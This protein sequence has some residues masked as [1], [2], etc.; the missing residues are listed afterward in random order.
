M[1]RNSITGLVL[2]FVI[3]AGS[4]YLMQPSEEELKR[5][6]QLQDS[7]ARARAGIEQIDSDTS[8]TPQRTAID[9]TLLS[10]PFGTALQGEERLVTLE[11]EYIRASISTKGGRVKS[12]ALKGE[13]T[14]DGQPLVLFDGDNNKFG[15][16][17]SAAGKNIITNDLYFTTADGDVHVTGQ[18]SASVTL[19]LT[20]ADNKYIDY[21]YSIKGDNHNLGFT[22]VTK[23]LQ[24]IVAPTE[25][26]LILNWEAALTQKEK[27]IASERQRSTLYYALEDGEVDHLGTDGDDEEELKEQVEWISF[28]QHFFSNVLVA[29]NGFKGGKVNVYS[30]PEANIIKLFSANMRLDF[31]RQEV[32]TY[33]MHFFFGPNQYKVLKA[34]GYGLEK[35]IDMGW[36]PMKWINRFITIPVF[37]FLDSFNWSY[38]LVI[39][40][41]T[42]MLK[43]VL[44]PLTYRSYVSMAKM[45]VL[46]PE[47]DQ[48]KEKVGQDNPTL[49]QQE[50]LKLYKQAGVNPLGGCIPLLLQMPFTIA[51]FFFFPNLFELRGESFLW[52]KDLS[53]YDSPITFPRIPIIGM[54]HISLMCILMTVATLLSTWYNNSISGATG[55][56]K[57]IGYFMPLIFLF[58]LN[59]FP[60]GLNYYYLLSTVFTFGQQLVIRQLIN[61]DKIL[62]II[63]ANKKKPE[64]QKKSKFQQRMEEYMRQQQAQAKKGKK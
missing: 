60:A 9:S 64:A 22:I 1:D 28:K 16:F 55:Q 30:S 41:L 42:V 59:S 37:T 62:A 26:Q 3:I 11:N 36:G 21:I 7:L 24:D 53:T 31:G 34:H 39:L 47:M 27:D 56:M 38:G 5:E 17:F 4:F 45:R 18:D 15:L 23:G 48:I 51:F 40:I 29:E 20:Y 33:P 2:I 19:R 54:D 25:S 46:K 10:G 43:L 14:Y 13:T 52:V 32:N 12:V 63:E 57:Y 50:Y 49:L 61:D 44:S 58:V 6:R 8:A 35:Q